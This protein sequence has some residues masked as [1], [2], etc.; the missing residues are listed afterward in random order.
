[1]KFK[2]VK[3]V[4][5]Q[6]VAAERK[7]Y[8]TPVME[9]SINLKKLAQ[10]IAGQCTVRPADCYAV[11]TAL[12]TNVVEALAEG[13]IVKMGD[14]GTLR[15]SLSSEGKMAEEEV[16]DKAIKSARIL[17]RPGE[18]MRDMLGT[19]KYQKEPKEK[20]LQ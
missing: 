10:R 11:L 20:R 8:A 5:P 15:L 19:I 6:D 18:G 16:N 1:M 4:N 2:V 12:E 13:K 14:L 7:F 17:Y 9:G 3:R